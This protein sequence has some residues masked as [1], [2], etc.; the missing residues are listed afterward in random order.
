MQHIDAPLPMLRP[1]VAPD[2]P[3]PAPTR[4]ELLA[5]VTSITQDAKMPPGVR[6]ARFV[7]IPAHLYLSAHDM[8]RRELGTIVGGV[9]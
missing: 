4:E 9:E 7:R 6:N 8:V 3:P 1:N 2:D 5:I